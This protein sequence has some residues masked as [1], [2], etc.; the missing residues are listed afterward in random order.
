MLTGKI[1]LITGAA[2]GIGRAIA[3]GMAGRGAAVAVNYCTSEKAA[4]ELVKE[5]ED[6]GGQALPYQADVSN[7]EQVTAM[8]AAIVRRWGA[9]DI[10]VNNAGIMED[11]LLVDMTLEE[12]ERV[13]DV[14]LRSAF[15]CTRAVIPLLQ[16]RG[17][18]RIINI[19]SQAALAGSRRHVHYATAKAG[20]L[21]FTYSLAKELGPY[22]ITV[23]AVSPGRIVTDMIKERMQGREEEW[24]QQT[25]LAQLGKPE[26]VAAAVAFLASDEASYITGANLNVNGG[27]VMG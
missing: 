9:L 17:G 22:G 7:P 18:G 16:A 20:L 12:W 21:G 26:E 3:I 2:R 27:L 1:A 10:L 19:S 15:L 25:P 11:N 5:I 24:L 8:V 6:H 4:L 14:N 23:N 13:I